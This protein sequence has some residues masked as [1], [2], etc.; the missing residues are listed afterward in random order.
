M[1][2]KNALYLLGMLVLL[3]ALL[4]SV[5]TVSASKGEPP[6]PA[7]SLSASGGSLPPAGTIYVRPSQFPSAL[8]NDGSFENGPPPASA[9]TEVTNTTCEW[10]DDWSSVWALGAHDG[11]IDFW[12]GGYCSGS[13]ATSSVSQAGIAVPAS[14]NDLHFWYVAYRP[15]SDDGDNDHAYVNVNGVQVWSLPL[16]QANNTYPTWVEA[17]VPM[18]AYAGQNVTLEFGAVSEGASTGNIRFDYISFGEPPP[19]PPRCRAGY[20]EVTVYTQDFEGSFPPAG[21]TAQNTT[22]G[23]AGIPGWTN[24]DPSARTNLTGGTGLFAIADSDQCGNGVSMNASMMSPVFDLTGLTEPKIEFKYD[25][26]DFSSADSGMVDVS[27]DGGAT[28]TNEHTWTNDDRGPKTYSDYINGGN[29]NAVQVRWNYVSGWDWWWEVDNMVLTACEPIPSTF[30]CNADPEGFENGVPPTGWT[31]Q[32]AEPNGPQWTSIAGCG[33]TGN[34]TNGSGEAAC[35]SSDVFGVAE[36]DTSLVSPAFDLTGA[37]TAFVNYTVNYQNFANLDYFDVDISTDNGA[38]W[39]T[40]LSWNEDHG[41]FGAPPG[42][43][44]NIDLSAYVG[45]SGLKLRYRYYDPNADDWDWYVQ[46]DNV[47]LTCTIGNPPNIDVDPESI[48]LK[49]FPD[50][51]TVRPLDITNDGD[52]DLSWSI[53]EESLMAPHS[54]AAPS[55]VSKLGAPPPVHR[56][57]KQLQDMVGSR[58]ADVVQDGSFEAGSPSPFWNEFS[59]NFGTPLCT[60]V[61]CGTGGGTGPLTGDW[62]AWFG[63]IAAYEVGDVSQS[64]TIPSGGPA[65]L[66]FWIEQAA[67]SGD[68]AD[69]LDVMIDGT[70]LWSTYGN[71][72]ECDA[73]GYR[74]VTLDVSAFADGGAHLL[75]FNSE[76]QGTDVTNF[77]VDDVMLV[78]GA[79]MPCE[80]PSDIPWLSVSPTAGTTPPMSTDTVNVTFDSTGLAPGMYT[81]NLCISSNDP[82]PGPGDGTELVIVPITLTVSQ[83]YTPSISLVKTVGT[84][85][86]VCAPTSNITVAPGTTVY[87]CYTVTNTGNVTL[88]LHTLVDD[89]L[90]TIF[91]GFNY[92]LAPG[93]SVNTV[94]AGLSIPAVINTPTTNTATW[95]ASTLT[96]GLTATATATAFVDVYT[97]SCMYPVENFEMGVPPW[98]WSVVTNAGTVTWTNIAGCG[99]A[100]NYTGGAGDA[101]CMSPGT[102]MMQPYDAELRSP[103]FSLVG[104]SNVTISYLANYQN[105]AGI[106][107]LNFDISTD[108]GATWTTL[109]SWNSDYGAFQSPPGVFPTIDLAPYLGMSNLMVRWHYFYPQG[110]GLGW[111]AQIDEVHLKC[112]MSPPTAVTLKGIS[113]SQSN[114]PVGSLPLAALPTSVALA[115][116][117]AY[118]MR[119]KK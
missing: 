110:S 61:A 30:T 23:C 52:A 33:E 43:N 59:T 83:P 49:L 94:A 16:L 111:Y 38:T 45:M 100:G 96:S 86:G 60:A 102:T 15:D 108:G 29:S 8:I 87:Y 76:I 66:S 99:E 41:S 57:S 26:N 74:Q 5:L 35:V 98:G 24:T 62:W 42:E 95:T 32:T 84:T 88:D 104:Y 72:P 112:T 40:L 13:P 89:Q 3:V 50:E 71:S 12:A 79:A 55:G 116:G 44:V 97:L 19:P 53:D 7:N 93:A 25:Y 101:A 14:N 65:T 17:V 2:R 109:R 28:W 37:S 78:A 22:T 106:D 91:S 20:Q 90:G 85:P 39:T 9:W 1:Q 58:S 21:W 56:S 114:L 63:G 27:T 103:V 113:A 77:F 82:D 47:G 34:Y 80:V 105:W 4:S 54:P 119:R 36:F 64:V 10:I 118:T 81:G 75:E 31:I 6:A 107:R 46:V 115:L 51:S 68:P 117:A 48:A 67:C 18:T 11:V 73:V 69:Y 70:T 92:S